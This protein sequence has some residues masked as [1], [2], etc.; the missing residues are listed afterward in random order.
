MSC[1]KLLRFGDLSFI[2][3]GMTRSFPVVENSQTAASMLIFY[4][5]GFQLP[6]PH[7]THKGEK[8]FVCLNFKFPGIR[9]IEPM[10]EVGYH[11]P[12]VLGAHPQER[13]LVARIK[14]R[15]RSE[16]FSHLCC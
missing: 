8:N 4:K 16:F 5:D 10:R 11:V 7:H 13:E 9:L 12:N 2:A 6:P 14:P 1:I 15:L 3:A